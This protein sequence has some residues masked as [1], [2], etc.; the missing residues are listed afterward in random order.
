MISLHISNFMYKSGHFTRMGS[1][2]CSTGAYAGFCKEG[3]LRFQN[4][5]VVYHVGI[6]GWCLDHWGEGTPGNLFLN[7]PLFPVI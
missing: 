4:V 1:E 5:L 3:G 6:Y 2:P 7:E